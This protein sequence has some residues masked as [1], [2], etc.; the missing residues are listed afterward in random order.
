MKNL[1]IRTITGVIFI[2]IITF[3]VLY[4]SETIALNVF[5][6]LMCLALYEYRSI[7]M[8]KNIKLSVFFYIA[9]VVIY[10]AVYACMLWKSISLPTLM[11]VIM[12][13]FLLLILVE[14]FGKREQPFVHTAYAILGIVWIVTPFVLIGLFPLLDSAYRGGSPYL[15]LMLFVFI[16]T[17]DTLAYCTGSLIGRHKLCERISPK[18]TW[19]GAVG[20]AVLTLILAAFV[21]KILTGLPL[22]EWHWMGF[23][24]ITVVFGT[25]GD[26]SESLFKRQFGVKDS[27]SFL[28]GHGGIL[29]RFDSFLFTSPLVLFYLYIITF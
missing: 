29:D 19:E 6:I 1:I 2:T 9:A 18:K 24:A 21:P 20:A 12:N 3:L 15:L 16:W 14:V 28:P 25:L 4:P 23:A 10:G 8:Q 13:M 27:G 7:L 11:G 22:N 5:L 17:Y 26:L